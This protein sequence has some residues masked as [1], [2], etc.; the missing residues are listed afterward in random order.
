M[1]ESYACT[2][3]CA[4]LNTVQKYAIYT[5]LQK[6]TL[7]H[8]GNVGAFHCMCFNLQTDSFLIVFL[9]LNCILRFTFFHLEKVV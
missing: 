7:P 2:K 8:D 1:I 9:N 3:H 4:T 6:T 5:Y